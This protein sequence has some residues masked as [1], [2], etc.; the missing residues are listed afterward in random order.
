MTQSFTDSRV[1]HVLPGSLCRCLSFFELLTLHPTATHCNTLQHMFCLSMF[2]S[3]SL[4]RCLSF[5]LPFYLSSCPPTRSLPRVTCRTCSVFQCSFLST[6]PYRTVDMIQSHSESGVEH[7]LPCSLRGYLSAAPFFFLSSFN[8]HPHR[9][10]D[11][12]AHAQHFLSHPESVLQ[13][14]VLCM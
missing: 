5:L 13:E 1:E 11:A 14:K 3:S 6:Q 2:V 10:C 8:T 4:C 9:G 7:V 12:A